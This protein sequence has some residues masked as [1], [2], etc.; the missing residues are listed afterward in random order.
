MRGLFIFGYQKKRKKKDVVLMGGHSFPEVFTSLI[1]S[2]ERE[3]EKERAISSWR[4]VFCPVRPALHGVRFHVRVSPRRGGV[5]ASD[6]QSPAHALALAIVVWNLRNAFDRFG[7]CVC[8]CYFGRLLG[9]KQPPE[10]GRGEEAEEARAK[11][12]LVNTHA[13]MQH[14]C[15]EECVSLH[16]S[17]AIM[18]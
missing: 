3:R 17:S 14:F 9:T 15:Q 10:K 7:V 5:P 13:F 8:G 18:K 11:G 16:R 6:T 12:Y 2:R 1:R 4:V